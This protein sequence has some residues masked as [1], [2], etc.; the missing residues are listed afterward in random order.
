LVERATNPEDL[1]MNKLRIGHLAY[2]AIS[3]LFLS[4]L[5]AGCSSEGSS[6][7]T[8]GSTSGP[9]MSGSGNAT[10]GSSDGTA[11]SG[12]PGGGNSNGTAGSSNGTAGSSNPGG[13]NSSTAGSNPSGG[14][15]PGG[16]DTGTGGGG[17]GA[18]PTEP[19]PKPA[20][21]ICHE[22]YANDN[23]RN[24]LNYVNEFNG[25]TWAKPVN[26]TTVNSG[27]QIEL[28]ANAAVTDAGA[29]TG[30]AIMI[31]VNKGYQ[32]YH[33]TTGERLVN[34]V[35]AGTTGVRGAVRLPGGNTLL[36]VGDNKLRV[37]DKNGATVGQECT[38][39]GSGGDS[40]RVLTRDDA[41][42]NILLG[43]LLDLFI[44]NETCQQQWNA[45]LP[46]GS[47]AYSVFPRVGGGVWATSGAPS[48]VIEYDQAGTIVSQIGGKTAHP[49][50][51]LDFFS[52]FEILPNGNIVA[53]NWQGHVEAPAA[54]T[55]HLVEFDK[56]N[57]LVWKWGNQTLARQITNTLILR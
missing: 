57:K 51:G 47:K 5:G 43:R 27:R 53:A 33:P 4:A 7:G 30:K 17:G 8:G 44:V 10:A 40:L 24:Q 3:V 31:S 18:P 56:T 32:E 35:L 2:T 26:D 19:C 9:S 38:L 20:G 14:S 6:F 48:T 12:N 55:P 28:V 36:G 25:K 23:A 1:H 45:K 22:F 11:G 37:V 46:A 29:L 34:V 42:G 13:G 50:I 21:E 15:N 54:E 16:G 52:G 41:T 49:G 39:P